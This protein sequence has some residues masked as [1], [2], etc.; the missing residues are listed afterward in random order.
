MNRLS[1]LVLAAGLALG[2]GALAPV[3]HAAPAAAAPMIGAALGG[4]N[5]S[6]L[7]DVRYVT[8]CR[9]AVVYRRDRR[10]RPVQVRREVCRR[11]WVAG[12]RF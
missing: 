2:L 7:E 8:R 4:A 11:V 9:P 12:R 6:L 3:A 10:G 1:H 5:T